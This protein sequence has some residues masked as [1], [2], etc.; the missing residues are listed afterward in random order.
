MNR[1]NLVLG[2][3]YLVLCFVFA[4]D[5]PRAQKPTLAQSYGSQTD[6][7]GEYTGRYTDGKDFVVYFEKTKYGLAMRPALWTATQ[8]LQ[9]GAKDRFYV[10]DRTSRSAKFNR[11]PDGRVTSVTITG[12]EGEGLLLARSSGLLPVEL[13]LAGKSL[14]ATRTSSGAGIFDPVRTLNLAERVL[15]RFPTRARAVTQFLSAL[16]SKFSNSARYHVLLGNAY[17]A[18]GNRKLAAA[19]FKRAHKLDLKNADAISGLARLKALPSSA[20][21]GSSWRVPFRLARAFERPS[22]AEI[23]AVERDWRNRDL[24]PRDVHEVTRS[25]IKFGTSNFVVRIVSHLVRGVRHFGAIIVPVNAQPGCCPVIVEAKGVSI[26]YFDLNVENIDAPVYMG[27]A[28][29]RFIYVVPSFRGEVLKFGGSTYRSEGDRTNAWDGATDDAI[30]LLNV[31]LET[32]PEADAKRI[33][34]YGHSRGGTIALLMG[35]RDRRVRAVSAWAGPTDWFELM[36]TEGWTQEELFQEGMRIQ[37]NPEQTG[38][39]LIEH[40]LLK[41]I[42]GTEGVAEV[43]HRMLASSPLYFARRMPIVQLHYGIEDPFVPVRNGRRLAAELNKVGT[44][45]P[46]SFFYIGQGHDT[47]RLAAPHSMREFFVKHLIAR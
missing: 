12:M 43:R 18:A 13:L 30:A 15:V 37:A 47:D 7:Y 10:I 35:A 3:L 41:A 17:V 2:P 44:R 46:Q 45:R 36:G 21:N 11:G 38:G 33:G 29:E 34:V 42:R 5:F 39:Q 28:R 31:V 25:R 8:L 14:A 1:F 23:D 27:E 32:T 16:S 24:S 6:N 19:S 9:R 22:L 40:F 4:A 20:I 26:S